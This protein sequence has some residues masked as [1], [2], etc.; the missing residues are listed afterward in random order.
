MDF[1][2]L[3][4]NY[5]KFT[6]EYTGENSFSTQQAVEALT[7]VFY[8]YLEREMKGKIT[9]TSS[10]I[11]SASTYNNAYTKYNTD[12]F[13]TAYTNRQDFSQ[14]RL[15]KKDIQNILRWF[16]MLKISEITEDYTNELD[17][18][19]EIPVPKTKKD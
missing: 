8:N 6:P 19:L 12:K 4:S 1:S 2:L 7:H 18:I 14:E 15:M 10:S 17:N 16:S 3:E 5:Y 13:G 11:D 9:Y